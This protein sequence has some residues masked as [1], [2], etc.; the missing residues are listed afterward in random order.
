V[1]VYFKLFTVASIAFANKTLLLLLGLLSCQAAI[2]AAYHCY[3]CSEKKRKSTLLHIFTSFCFGNDDSEFDD[4][5]NGNDDG[6]GSSNDLSSSV[7]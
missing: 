4:K 6:N 2:L 3:H 5:C 7:L 1:G